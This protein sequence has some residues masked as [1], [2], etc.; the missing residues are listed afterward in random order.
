[1]ESRMSEKQGVVLFDGDDTLWET[2]ALYEKAKG[3]FFSLM[4]TL[5]F[6]YESVKERFALV[7]SANVTKY[8][9]SK[10]RFA[11]SMVE[12]YDEFS[13]AHKVSADPNIRQNIRN[14]GMSVFTEKASLVFGAEE[15]LRKVRQKFRIFLFTAGD[16]EV[17]KKRIAD[18]SLEKLF[19]RVII[20]ERKTDDEFRYI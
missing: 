3:K 2:Q 4:E 20:V 12:V 11:T 9:F 8:S 19:H 13:Q 14:I 17:Q 15:V 16:L 18:S 7:D 6:D 5:G 1:M 10:F